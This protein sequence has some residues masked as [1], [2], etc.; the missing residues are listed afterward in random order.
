MTVSYKT[1][2]DLD[3]TDF[4]DFLFSNETERFFSGLTDADI[5]SDGFALPPALSF[6][7]PN[8]LV[9]PDQVGVGARINSK[10]H[11]R[12][13][14][15]GGLINTYETFSIEQH[16]VSV[17]VECRLLF[18]ATATPD[19]RN[20]VEAVV[21]A[22]DFA[23]L[24]LDGQNYIALLES[25]LE[26]DGV[27]ED[28]Y[29]IDVGVHVGKL[30]SQFVADSYQSLLDSINQTWPAGS[31]TL[32]LVSRTPTCDKDGFQ[33]D[34]NVIEVPGE[35]LDQ[36]G[37]AESALDDAMAESA[38]KVDC[39]PYDLEYVHHRVGTLFNFPEIKIVSE[40]KWIRIGKCKL[41]KMKI[42][43]KIYRRTNKRALFVSAASPKSIVNTI[44]KGLLDCMIES[45]IAVGILALIT[46]GVALSGA[47]AAYTSAVTQCLLKKFGDLD[48]CVIHDVY[49]VTEYGEWQQV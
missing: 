39:Q 21:N 48:R 8:T 31:V 2:V 32:N 42:I 20:K 25:Q 4:C 44:K 35:G 15:T 6:A 11:L 30:G 38:Q 12:A 49:L 37:V 24:A 10:W 13:N 28:R 5:A 16:T 40:K 41:F 45:A 34:G 36:P 18:S 7:L 27:S 3:G 19:D 26:S 22:I 14:A 47:A 23:Q 17:T 9:P 29:L 33:F 1:D 43:T 46:G